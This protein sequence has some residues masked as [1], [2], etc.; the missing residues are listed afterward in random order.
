M[1]KNLWEETISVLKNYNLTWDDVDHIILDGDNVTIS[2][3][4]FE[5]VARETNYDSGWGAAEIRSDLIIRG[6]NW[7][8]ERAEYDGS[9][10]WE[11]KTLPIVPNETTTVTRLTTG[12]WGG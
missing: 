7:W 5:K 1:R 11:L 6:W 9:E 4:N 10:W 12:D 8:L 2:K 3:E